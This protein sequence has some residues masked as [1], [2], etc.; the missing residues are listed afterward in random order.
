MLVGADGNCGG[1]GG[2]EEEK[3]SAEEKEK[4]KKEKEEEEEKEKKKKPATSD[5]V[6]AC[7]AYVDIGVPVWSCDPENDYWYGLTEKEQEAE[8]E[9][10]YEECEDEDLADY[11][12]ECTPNLSGME[13]CAQAIKA[14][15]ADSCEAVFQA[16]DECSDWCLD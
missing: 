14:A 4:E 2:T 16:L 3:K 13:A 7:K 1:G 10:Y 8:L 5:K 15:K 11:Y 6:K 12:I 9:D